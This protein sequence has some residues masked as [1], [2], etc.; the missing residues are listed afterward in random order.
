MNNQMTKKSVMQNAD[1]IIKLGYCDLYHILGAHKRAGYTAGVYGW[2]ADVYYF[3]SEDYQ[4]TIA[5][6]T[7]YRPF[8]NISVDYDIVQKYTARENTII[9]CWSK[10]DYYNKAMHKALQDFIKDAAGVE[11]A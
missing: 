10:L 9:F 8:G 4:K 6:V 5:I 1:I 7:G 3:Y 11:I 2:N